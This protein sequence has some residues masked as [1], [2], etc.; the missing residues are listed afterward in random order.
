MKKDKKNHEKLTGNSLISYF[1]RAFKEKR[2][3]RRNGLTSN[4]CLPYEILLI[5]FLLTISFFQL[6]T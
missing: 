2:P 3:F 5:I 4:D 6:A 1:S